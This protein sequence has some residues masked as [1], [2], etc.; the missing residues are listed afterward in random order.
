LT[1]NARLKAFQRFVFTH[2]HTIPSFGPP[3]HTNPPSHDVFPTFLFHTPF[4]LLTSPLEIVKDATEPPVLVR[5]LN[6]AL[7]SSGA[8]T[9][10]NS[11]TGAAPT[12]T[13]KENLSSSSGAKSGS[14]AKSTGLS[15]T[16]IPAPSK[17][18]PPKFYQSF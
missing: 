2:L 3:P 12:R 14:A 8:V 13:K 4:L 18:L 1:L 15:C 5:S 7:T 16:F 10:T 17:S 6:K 11:N 9:T